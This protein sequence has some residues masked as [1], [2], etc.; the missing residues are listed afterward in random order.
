MTRNRPPKRLALTGLCFAIVGALA[1]SPTAVP[2]RA[3][4]GAEVPAPVQ[5]PATARPDDVVTRVWKADLGNSWV[6]GCPT[7]PRK[8]RAIDINHWDYDGQLQRGRIIVHRKAVGVVRKALRR[9]FKTGFAIHEMTP[10][11]KYNSSDNRSM[12]ADNT[13]GFSCRKIPGS[14][15]WSE[16]AKGTAIDMNPRRN[17]HVFSYKLLPGNA[18][19]FVKRRPVQKGMLTKRSAVSRVFANHGW[20]WGGT[21]RNPDYQHYSRSGR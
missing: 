5:Q 15:R 19:A 21:Y 11:Q 2:A 13:S 18:R 4:S 10:V 20:T 9:A 6:R 1:L 17:P 8:L 14:T 16:H 12:R 7:R 3:H